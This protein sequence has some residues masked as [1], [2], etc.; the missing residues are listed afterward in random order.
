MG[1]NPVNNIKTQPLL[2]G[3]VFILLVMIID[4]DYLDYVIAA[5]NKNYPVVPSKAKTVDM[6]MFWFEQFCM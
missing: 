1:G 4:V 6:Q 3:W 5:V 2:K